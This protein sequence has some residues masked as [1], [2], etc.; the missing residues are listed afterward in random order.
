MLVCLQVASGYLLKDD[1]EELIG[2]V[3]LV[4]SLPEALE[5]SQ[6]IVESVFEDLKVREGC[7]C[8]GSALDRRIQRARPPARCQPGRPGHLAHESSVYESTIGLCDPSQV[9]RELFNQMVEIC[10]QR[11][12]PP[13]SVLLCTNTMSLSMADISEDVCKEYRGSCIGKPTPATTSVPV[14]IPAPA[15]AHSPT[16]RALARSSS[17][18]GAVPLLSKRQLSHRRVLALRTLVPF[19]APLF[20]SGMRFL[21]PVW[22]ID[23]VELTECDYTRRG[24]SAAA[25]SMLRG[26][27]FEPFFF[28][29]CNRR[30]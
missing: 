27:F 13:G 21:H 9:K 25:E 11:A 15:P 24:T 17:M 5:K 10:K 23:E 28:D 7:P 22:F 8:I 14:H 26:L 6:V 18:R 16:D 20:D 19:L 4:H 12:V 3:V 2:R 1:V 29:G 30:R